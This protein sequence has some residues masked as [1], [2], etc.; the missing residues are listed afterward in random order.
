[1]GKNVASFSLSLV[2]YLTWVLKSGGI[3]FLLST[4]QKLHSSQFKF[5][6][7]YLY[8]SLSVSFAALSI[9]L[10]ECLKNQKR[11]GARFFIVLIILLSIPDFLR[12]TRVNFLFNLVVIFVILTLLGKPLFKMNIKKTLLFLTIFFPILVISPGLFRTGNSFS[13]SYLRDGYSFADLF[14]SITGYDSAMDAGFA[15]F[16]AQNHEIGFGRSYFEGLLRF[17]PRIFWEGKPREL[18]SKLNDIIFP[19][20]SKNVNFSFSGFSEPYYNF[21]ILGIIAFGLSIA[22]FSVKILKALSSK[23]IPIVFI[24][25]MMC[26]FSYNL[27]REISPQAILK[28]STRSQ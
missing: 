11:I 5:T 6:N 12:G 2:A 25:A 9:G 27:M 10:I 7:G 4:R 3:D 13:V 18:D 23:S 26:A 24:C 15:V 21:R 1:M 22:Y 14:I 17:V 8:T 19:G 28:F 20:L 16:L